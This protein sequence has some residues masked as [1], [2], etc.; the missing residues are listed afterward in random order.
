MHSY[1][2]PALNERKRDYFLD[3]YELF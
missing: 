2:G 1:G 3:L